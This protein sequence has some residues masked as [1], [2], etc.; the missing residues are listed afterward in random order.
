MQR[1]HV[2]LALLWYKK[3]HM[4]S[5]CITKAKFQ[6]YKPANKLF[7]KAKFVAWS[8]LSHIYSF[9][10]SVNTYPLSD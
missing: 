6:I 9:I 8:E 7:L 1:K 2:R 3:L 5:G 10:H 4:L